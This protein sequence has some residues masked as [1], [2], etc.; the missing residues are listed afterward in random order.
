[1]Q[2]V[3][4]DISVEVIIVNN[5]STDNTS[6]VAQYEWGKYKS[7]IP[8]FIV[9]E[10]QPGLSYARKKG[11]YT[12]RYEYVI[13]CDDDNWLASKYV[14][15]AF[16]IMELNPIIG[17]LGGKITAV[18]E[19]NPPEWFEDVK[20]NY[21]VGLQNS[22]SGDI[23]SRGYV[24]G[25]GMVLRRSTYLNLEQLGFK[26][27]L[28]DRQGNHLSSGGDAEICMWY[29]IAGMKLWYAERLTLKH[30]IPK[31]RLQIDY[32]N[33]LK[34]SFVESCKWHKRYSWLIYVKGLNRNYYRNFKTALIAIIR[35]TNIDKTYLQCLI[36]PIFKVSDLNDFLFI[37][38]YFR[39]LYLKF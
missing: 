2:E 31:E 5:N 1:M 37:R 3:S 24:W 20:N 36:G 29:I 11:I 12:A 26:T 25:A 33:R 32:F 6:E 14:K 38:R 27:F 28:A 15:I 17:V 19:L 30:F 18:C 8:F 21:A 16:G 10:H 9:D 34:E 4:S 13:F 7:S 22:E 39:I 35:R 23:T